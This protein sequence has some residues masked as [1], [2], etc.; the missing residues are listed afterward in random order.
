MAAHREKDRESGQERGEGRGGTQGSRIRKR[1]EPI[2][3]G[4]I[5]RI[6]K[7]TTAKNK[8]FI[9]DLSDLQIQ[10]VNSKTVA[11]R[12]DLRIRGLRSTIGATVQKVKFWSTPEPLSNIFFGVTHMISFID[13]SILE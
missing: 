10:H 7:H 11:F 3:T 5:K 13:L 1:T 2:D 9:C 12:R 8:L 6:P 4:L